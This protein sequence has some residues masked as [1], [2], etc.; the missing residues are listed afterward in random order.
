MHK[1]RESV[2]R[3]SDKSITLEEGQSVKV[4]VYTGGKSVKYQRSTKAVSCKAGKVR[5][6]K[7]TLT[8]TGVKEGSC[9]ITL[10]DKNNK[11]DKCKIK[12]TV[13]EATYYTFRTEEL[14]ESHF[15]KHGAEFGD[16]T[17]QEYLDKANALID[18]TSD[19]VLTKREEDGDYLFFNTETGEF[20][21]LSDDGYIRTFFIPDDGIDYWNRQ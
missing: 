14:F 21:V 15:L 10:Y 20:L 13:T 19:D 12:V 2:S 6:G 16:I 11:S 18:D 9:T 4:T 17:K 1:H 3:V 5:K 8:V 7:F